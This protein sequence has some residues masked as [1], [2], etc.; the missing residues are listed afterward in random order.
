MSTADTV[1]VPPGY[2]ARVLIAW[3]DP[4]SDGPAFAQ[5]ASNSAADQAQQWGMHNDGIVYFPINGLEGG[6]ARPEQ[7]VHRRRPAVPRRHRELERREDGQVAERPR[8]QH[9]RASAGAGADGWEVVRPSRYARRITG[10]T[11][12]DI[13]GPAAGDPTPEDERRPDRAARCSARSTTAP[14]ATRRGARTS[15]ARRTSTATSARPRAPDAAREPLRHQRRRR[16]LPVAH[17]RHPL[18]ASTS[19]RTSPTASAGSSRSTRSTRSRRRS[20]APRW[21]ASSTRAPGCRRPATA[22]SS[23]TWATTSSSSTSTATCPT[24]PWRKALRRGI[25]PLDDGMLYVAKFNADGTGEWL[26]LTPDNPALAGWSLERHPDQHPR[27]GRRRRRHEDGPPR[28]DRHVPRRPHGDRHADQQHRR[29]TGTNPVDAANP[30]ARNAYGHI[31]RWDYEHDFTEPTFWWDIFALAG[32][33]A[34][35]APT[36]RP[37]SATS[38]ARPTGSTS[39][40]AGGCGSRPTCRAA[41]STA[42]PTPASATTRCCAP[43]RR[44]GRPAGS[45]SGRTS[46]RS[47]ACFVTPDERTM[48]VGIQHPGEAPTRRQRPGQPEAVQLLAR[49]RRRRPPPLVA[50]SSSPRT[51]AARSA[52]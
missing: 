26:P 15:P 46:A 43:T 16:R 50:A 24:W 48:F 41:R 1:V 28:V 52:S 29:G 32:D 33:P 12:I 36:A 18:P 37:S 45:W 11:P 13:G 30:R 23:S 20:S 4:V 51:T 9:H 34:D 7:R 27:R 25:N 44:R 22:G 31:V 10:Q 8:R 38:T 49:R 2:T 5:D 17:H 6:P 21:A 42:A 14:W 3:G 39:P 35:P 19:S 47:P 40:R